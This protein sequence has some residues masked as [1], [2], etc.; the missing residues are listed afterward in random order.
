MVD[1]AFMDVGS[2]RREP[3]R[4]S[5]TRQHRGA[6]LVRQVLRA[7]RAA[8]R[9]RAGRAGDR[10]AT[11]CVAWTVGG[12]GTG[13]CDRRDCLG[14]PRV[15]GGDAR[16]AR[17]G[18]GAPRRGFDRG[19][20]RPGRRDVIVP[21]GANA[22]RERPVPSPRAA[23]ASWCARSPSNR[24]GCGLD[25][26]P[27]STHGSAC[28]RR[29]PLFGSDR[30]GVRRGAGAARRAG[31]ALLL[32]RMHRTRRLGRADQLRGTRCDSRTDRRRARPCAIRSTS[33]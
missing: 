28:A 8:A 17:A 20:A 19:G 13:N 21:A 27:A 4:P 1:E 33:S 22:G 23:P 15:G 2:C 32:E 6:A 9:L 7:G 18:S 25:C 30:R 16:A 3:R 11:G 29:S 14:R 5:R 10:G 31:P 12:S 26:R 24:L